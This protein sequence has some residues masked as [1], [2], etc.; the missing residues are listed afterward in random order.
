MSKKFLTPINLTN[1]SS[2]PATGSEGDLYFNTTDNVVKIYADGI[3]TELQGGAGGGASVYYQAEAPDGAELGALWVDSDST[4][5]G[6]SSGGSGGTSL[7]YWTEDNNG[8]LIPDI[9]N[10]YSI[11]SSAYRVKDLYLGASSLYLQNPASASANISLSVDSSG[12]LKIND[13]KIITESNANNNLN[14]TNY[15][16]LQYAQ[17]A[18]A[19][20]VSYLVDS[21]PGALDTL[22]ELANALG[23][24]QNFATTVTN[25]L[26]SKLSISSAST[27]YQTKET[28][29]TISS[30]YTANINDTVFVNTASSA[31]TVTLPS[32][33]IQGSKIKVLDVSANAQNNNITVL[34]NGYNIGGASAYIINT[35]DSSAEFLFINSSKGW[36]ITSE[37]ISINKPLVPTAVSAVDIGTSRPYNNGAATVSFTPS[38]SGD[39]ATS[40]TV[41]S[42]P[43]SY[44]TTGSSSPLVVTGLQSNTSYTFK[45]YA[46]NAAGNSAE[47]TASSSITATTVPEAPTISSIDS[48]YQRL[49][50]NFNAGGT[51]GKSITSY[52]GTRSGGSS[53]SVSSPIEFANLT[54]G[55]EYICS[56]TAVNDNGSSLSSSS[57]NATPY[58]ATGG[59]TA[60]SG[61]YRYHTFT[62]GSTFD[63]SG[64]STS[65][66]Y[67]IL[68]GGGGGGGGSDGNNGSGGGGAGGYLSGTTSVSTTSYSVVV[69]GGGSA[70]SN[71][72]GGKGNN[73]SFNSITAEGGGSGTRSGGGG[74]GGS[75]GGA[76]AISGAGPY[77]GGTA[78][79]GQGYNGGTSSNAS[80]GAGSGG[81]GGAGSVG[82]NGASNAGGG[83]GNGVDISS[84]LNQSPSTT[85]IAGG[86]GGARNN[87]N[88][89]ASGATSYGGGTANGGA[90][91]AN[92]GGGGSGITYL[93]ATGG[94]GGSGIVILRYLI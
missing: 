90:G 46:T 38:S 67:V 55:T 22:N 11:G 69:G 16:T 48:R 54:G 89:G 76:G 78:S 23:D 83:G 73:S 77:S 51:G 8:N 15:A 10:I 60:T 13:S 31:I 42:T 6:G 32:Y 56:V 17:S 34:G 87:N 40:F 72:S 30:N 49:L 25:A 41:I 86:G 65:I 59:T 26:S 24:D 70:G 33:P 75:G 37:Y 61:S 94:S 74:A 9:D 18:S 45:V 5:T 14:L 62:S 3:W 91:T 29:T 21:A 20:A 19:A 84:F 68:A 36:N 81:G 93:G 85:L 7:L 27:T 39:S 88:S 58:T 80:V 53:S 47:S 64:P 57:L 71:S 82:G 28:L 52:V 92:K 44:T 79:I 66:S 63:F 2:D 1:L 35:P 50:L 43:G 4:G 12:N